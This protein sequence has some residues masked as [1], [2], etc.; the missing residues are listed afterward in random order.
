[1]VIPHIHKPVA[2][3]AANPVT[4]AAQV[5]KDE[6][7]RPFIIVREYA[8]PERPPLKPF[9]NRSTKPHTLTILKP[10]QKEKTV[11]E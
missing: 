3:T 4:I 5:V 8:S 10:R 7:G 2:M 6:Q 11:W 9:Q 1:M